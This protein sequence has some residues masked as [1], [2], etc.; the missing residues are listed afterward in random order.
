MMRYTFWHGQCRR[1][2]DLPWLNQA[3]ASLLKGEWTS[4]LYIDGASWT[5]S[6]I[7]DDELRHEAALRLLDALGS[8]QAS[9]E[10]LIF[11]NATLSSAMD[12]ALAQALQRNQRLTSITLR[13]L[14]TQPPVQAVN[15]HQQHQQAPVHEPYTLPAS[16]FLQQEQ[17]ETLHLSKLVLNEASC[18]NLGRLISDSTKLHTL[19][20]DAVH[21]T[22]THGLTG[23]LA[24][25][26][27]SKSLKTLKLINL[28]W[29]KRDIS[30]LLLALTYNRF[31]TTVH[32]EGL[33]LNEAYAAELARLIRR[34]RS[35]TQLSLRR[36]QL[37]SS[38]LEIIV[39][40]GFL[41]DGL[42]NQQQNHNTTLQ[43]LFLSRNPLGSVDALLEY[44]TKDTIMTLQEVCLVDTKLTRSACRQVARAI[45]YMTLTHLGLDGNYMEYEGSLVRAS[46]QHNT[47]LIKLLDR[48]PRF[49]SNS[50]TWKAIQI[51]LAANQD[52]RRQ[53]FFAMTAH[54][55]ECLPTLLQKEADP[56]VLYTLVQS[57]VPHM[58]TKESSGFVYQ[59]PPRTFVP[60]TRPPLRWGHHH[61]GNSM[62]R[63]TCPPS[64]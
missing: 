4:P 3:E 63:P 45:R 60:S 23:I 8:P 37:T 59:G 5:S 7:R 10:T 50:S 53:R 14:K 2:A 26:I 47:H 16:V 1:S 40:Q 29:G 17:L 21:I 12:E 32:L 31:L 35:L 51:L 13:N 64:A 54:C 38:A 18:L 27:L 62:P 20:L 55:S 25:L 34:N 48:L 41:F 19:V 39:R 24:A 61:H 46:L 58:P 15:Q 57:A 28:T 44:L 6:T 30:R 52:H 42:E 11:Q 9:A 22:S 56:Q 33:S 43:R 36:N 49:V